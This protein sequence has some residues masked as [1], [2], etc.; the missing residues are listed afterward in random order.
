MHPPCHSPGPRQEVQA[1]R[2]CRAQAG[3]CLQLRGQQDLQLLQELWLGQ[4]WLL[5][6]CVELA[7]APSA[8]HSLAGGYLRSMNNSIQA[9]FSLIQ[10]LSSHP[11]AWEQ[12]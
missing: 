6:P 11:L 8:L 3:L 12:L 2:W 10:D 4:P 9:F 1:Y 5:Q 7:D